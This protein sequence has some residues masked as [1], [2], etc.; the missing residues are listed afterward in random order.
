MRS[1][2]PCV[3][4]CINA[5]QTQS[6]RVETDIKAFGLPWPLR[7]PDS[8]E[9]SKPYASDTEHSTPLKHGHQWLTTAQHRRA[10]GFSLSHRGKVPF[11][12][13][14]PPVHSPI[15]STQV[16]SFRR[17]H[18]RR[19]VTYFSQAS[20]TADH[21]QG[22]RDHVR[23]HYYL[24]GSKGCDHPRTRRHP[25]DGRT[26]HGGILVRFKQSRITPARSGAQRVASQT[27]RCLHVATYA[28]IYMPPSSIGSHMAGKSPLPHFRVSAWAASRIHQFA[29]CR[30]RHSHRSTRGHTVF[31]MMVTAIIV[32]A[33]ARPSPGLH[34]SPYRSHHCPALR[35]RTSDMASLRLTSVSNC[36][37]QKHGFFTT[38]LFISNV[39]IHTNMFAPL[40]PSSLWFLSSCREMCRSS[41]AGDDCGSHRRQPRS[42]LASSSFFSGPG[43]T[44][45]PRTAGHPADGWTRRGGTH[46]R[47][48]QSRITSSTSG[49]PE[50]ACQSQRWQRTLATHLT[51]Q[52]RDFTFVSLPTS[53]W[54]TSQTHQSEVCR[55]ICNRVGSKRHGFHRIVGDFRFSPP[56]QLDIA[57]SLALFRQQWCTI[58]YCVQFIAGSSLWVSSTRYS[59]AGRA[60]STL[61]VGQFRWPYKKVS[62]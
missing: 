5:V 47:S 31:I 58:I 55:T 42:R 45:K 43:V 11:L 62:S 27:Q 13:S 50:V 54:A 10:H 14:C 8:V 22:S 16:R 12:P 7:N 44:I 28:S 20:E 9:P 2:P 57:V 51:S 56:E 32:S 38:G 61:R 46:G 59:A 21:T 6:C 33:E 36:Q 39:A 24:I 48:K 40:L 25:A 35:R 60:W 41:Q 19:S 15:I 23:P 1:Q 34:S 3:G 17:A 4:L 53:V 37:S 18:S 26:S 29:T 52:D 30:T 49:I